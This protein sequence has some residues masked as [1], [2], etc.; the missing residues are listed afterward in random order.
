MDTKSFSQSETWLKGIIDNK[1]DNA[2][3]YLIANKIDC[4]SGRLISTYQGETLAEKYNIPYYEVSALSGQNIDKVFED[5][6]SQIIK[7]KYVLT[8]DTNSI[9]LSV[10]SYHRKKRRKTECC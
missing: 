5:I 10:A 1:L 3:V 7:N 8:C 9:R 6:V 2:L 4:G